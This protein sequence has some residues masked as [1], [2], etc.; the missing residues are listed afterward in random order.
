MPRA[1]RLHTQVKSSDENGNTRAPCRHLRSGHKDIWGLGL[2]CCG[3]RYAEHRAEKQKKARGLPNVTGRH[4]PMDVDA[5]ISSLAALDIQTQ[6]I[7]ITNNRIPSISTSLGF[8]ASPAPTNEDSVLGPPLTTAEPLP[9]IYSFG[10]GSFILLPYP[11]LPPH[12]SGRNPS[13]GIDTLHGVL[14]H[15]VIDS[16]VLAP[17]ITS[18]TDPSVTG[19]PVFPTY[20]APIP[21]T[22]YRTQLASSCT[23][24]PPVSAFAPPPVSVATGQ[25]NDADQPPPSPMLVDPPN[26]TAPSP[27]D[28]ENSFYG[29]AREAFGFL[30]QP[31]GN[32]GIPWN[33]LVEMRTVEYRFAP[34]ESRM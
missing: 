6:E 17:Q 34:I 19:G 27:A 26:A 21:T 11:I 30:G 5:V 7:G 23:F 4:D 12:W 15:M 24:V 10:G 3:R 2:S 29:N 25:F 13:E 1:P 9:G 33:S 14:D 16:P 18:L 22:G 8:D 31:G 28:N 20:V 32:G